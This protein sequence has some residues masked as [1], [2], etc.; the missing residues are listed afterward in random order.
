MYFYYQ[1]L[2]VEETSLF[3]R[4]CM[5]VRKSVSICVYKNR[6]LRATSPKQ[7][8]LSKK[9]NKSLQKVYTSCYTLRKKNDLAHPPPPPPHLTVATPA[10]SYLFPA[11][12][13]FFVFFT[14]DYQ[15]NSRRR[16]R[17]YARQRERERE[18]EK[19][20]EERERTRERASGE[21]ARKRAS[22]RERERVHTDIYRP[23]SRRFHSQLPPR[24]SHHP[25]LPSPPLPSLRAYLHHHL[26][27]YYPQVAW[28]KW[29]HGLVQ[30]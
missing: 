12:I 25:P 29:L 6:T 16:Q 8:S 22:E 3:A 17:A 9:E 28:I 13:C 24:S 10:E 30:V 15:D 7:Q 19:S 27:A 11:N 4:A 14:Q 5:C 2:V 21:R 1:Q 18:R 20:R 23:A 26:A